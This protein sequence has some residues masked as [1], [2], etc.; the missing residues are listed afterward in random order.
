MNAINSLGG[1]TV[2]VQ[3]ADNSFT[4]AA[5][6]RRNMHIDARQLVASMT[7][8]N[9]ARFSGA[10]MLPGQVYSSRTVAVH[11]KP[12]ENDCPSSNLGTKPNGLPIQLG[13]FCT[14]KCNYRKTW[15]LT[16]T[17]YQRCF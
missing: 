15:V 2:D 5:P 8:T 4:G 10:N 1:G 9:F 6:P 3:K 12:T 17:Q 7:A 11:V 16:S 14:N 13:E